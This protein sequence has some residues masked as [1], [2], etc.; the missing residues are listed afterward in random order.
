MKICP[1][2]HDEYQDQVANCLECQVSLQPFVKGMTLATKKGPEEVDLMS[3]VMVFEGQLPACKELQVLLKRE[4]IGCVV[5]PV[6]Q[7]PGSYCIA[8]N[9]DRV[10]LYAEIVKRQFRAMVAKENANE[11]KLADV[12]LDGGDVTCPACGHIGVLLDEQ[13]QD[14]GL[15]LSA[16]G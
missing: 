4:N 2:C 13:C 16:K 9:P 14:C 11:V 7:K 12:N 5:A 1:Q 3:A 10:D 15:V 6:T 8:I